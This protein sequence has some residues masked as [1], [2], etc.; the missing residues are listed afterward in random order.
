MAAQC[1]KQA[2]GLGFQVRPSHSDLLPQGHRPG[3]LVPTLI[4]GNLP[5]NFLGSIPSD[6]PEVVAPRNSEQ[7]LGV[8]GGRY[9]TGEDLDFFLEPLWGG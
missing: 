6:L 3:E 2:R 9:K 8:A 5:P 1:C 7:R 4:P